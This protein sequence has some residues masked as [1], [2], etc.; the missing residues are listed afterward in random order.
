M[1]K[2]HFRI[3]WQ[4]KLRHRRYSRS[5]G[6]GFRRYGFGVVGQR[7]E[8]HGTIIEMRG[9]LGVDPYQSVLEPVRVVALREILA[10][11]R[12][13]AFGSIDR[14]FD[15]PHRLQ[16]QVLELHR[17]DEIRV[18]YESPVRYAHVG[19]SRGNRL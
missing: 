2:F 1:A 17:L 5:I 12:T 8:L 6:P 10:R 4:A 13:A 11:V 18:P 15:R 7:I 16:Q 9:A 3:G 19:E 14:G